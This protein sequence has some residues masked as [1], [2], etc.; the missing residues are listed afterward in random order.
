ME[1]TEGGK[2]SEPKYRTTENT[3]SERE[4]RQQQKMNRASETYVTVT[5]DLTF[6]SWGSHK[7]RR[8][9]VGLRVSDEI[10][11][12]TPILAK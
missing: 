7:V 2:I 12:N 11:E 5:K 3:Q 9:S 8:N 4:K 10:T 1:L 6:M